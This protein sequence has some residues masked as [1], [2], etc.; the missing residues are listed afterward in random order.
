[1]ALSFWPALLKKKSTVQRDILSYSNICED[2]YLIWLIAC[3]QQQ[4]QQQQHSI[5]P[6]NIQEIEIYKNSTDDNR[7]AGCPK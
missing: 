2:V 6:Y 7:G 3:Q 1:M 5:S 4:Q